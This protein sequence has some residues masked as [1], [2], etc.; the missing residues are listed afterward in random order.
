[1]K[2]TT[3]NPHTE[4][5]PSAAETLVPTDRVLAIASGAQSGALCSAL[6]TAGQPEHVTALANQSVERFRVASDAGVVTLPFQV[7]RY[8][9]TEVIG[10]GGMGVVYLAERIDAELHQHVA[11][12][13]LPSFAQAEDR[14]RFVRE[15]QILA[16]MEHPNIA[17]FMDGGLTSEGQP[18]FAMEWVQ[19]APLM[20][21]VRAE[22]NIRDSAC[23]AS[24][25]LTALSQRARLS[26]FLKICDAVQYAHQRLVVH[27]D[28][29]PGNILV[30]ASG[31]PK[32][33]DFGIA[34]ILAADQNI[35]DQTV[36]GMMTPAYAAPEQLLGQPV[37]TLTD[38]FALGVILYE[39]L[40]DSRPRA[41][42]N[43]AELVRTVEQALPTPSA[44]LKAT[45]RVGVQGAALAKRPTL[46]RVSP[47]L[48]LI[49]Q[50]A[51][52]FEPAR[53]YASAEALANDVRAA[54]GARPIHARADSWRYRFGKLLQRNPA[55]SGAFVFAL[56][57]LLSGLT[58][59]V[60]MTRRANAQAA[61]AD[62]VKEFVLGMFS[63]SD[64]DTSQLPNVSV[65]E[66]LDASAAQA[67]AATGAAW[68]QQPEVL[69]EIQT[70]M[71]G[72]YANLGEFK[73]AL[74]LLD[75]AQS[76]LT[77]RS[78][79]ESQPQRA[80]SLL[81]RAQ[82]QRGLGELAAANAAALQGVAIAPSRSNT[83]ARLQ[84]ELALVQTELGDYAA[85]Q[86]G[87]REALGEY[88]AP[89]AHERETVEALPV[90][91]LALANLLVINEQT[92]AALELLN[93]SLAVMV[94]KVGE[95]NTVVARLLLQRA[96][97]YDEQGERA[98]AALDYSTSVS[99]L[100][101]LV[102][103]AHPETL[104]ARDLQ[105]FF[106]LRDGNSAGA[107]TLLLAAI[108]E[109]TAALGVRHYMI[110]TLNTSLS[111][112][113]VRRG[114][115]ARA[116]ALALP[117]LEIREALFSKNAFSVLES[118][119]IVSTILIRLNRFE[120]AQ[121][122]VQGTIAVIETAPPSQRSRRL[123][124]AQTR[125]AQIYQLQNQPR[126]ALTLYQAIVQRE[127]RA[128]SSF[129]LQPILLHL[130]KAALAV[131]EFETARVA[132]LRSVQ[133]D[134]SPR[135]IPAHRW[136]SLL[137]QG[138]VQRAGPEPERAKALQTLKQALLE[139]QRSGATGPDVEAMRQQLVD[140]LTD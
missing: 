44:A 116:L 40:T 58:V 138:L 132:A 46:E 85:A 108:S 10:R 12:K 42:A 31:E 78:V 3:Q 117:A 95:K 14:A 69:A 133:I 60:Q 105:A 109:G 81:T 86:R 110:A 8:R 26:L 126:A 21:Y 91:Q 70:A 33:L 64:P 55:A 115:Y 67:R 111:T 23:D 45:V 88:A 119:N 54:L 59:S 7:G 139:A 52:R 120:E 127:D 98:K 80:L 5:E 18:Y 6:D 125:S 32:L 136:T 92:S 39:L 11:L 102:G 30:D 62:A 130:V 68:Q 36:T 84:A 9:A 2:P 76:T 35:S 129:D 131:G 123:S 27:R 72:A 19:G 25:P 83:R 48:D 122:M 82:A 28:L 101:A 29:K 79:R 47:D 96:A 99:T 57:A 103:A 140:S 51:M 16:G 106:T 41:G 22:C 93:Q 118:R 73:R 74:A 71:A 100:T 124:S 34:K 121:A 94:P 77:A 17:H 134:A 137:A 38:V 61:R 43:V 66:L 113:Y 1:V 90:L 87:L 13:L 128:D 24:K 4:L 107:E 114:D 50:T 56:F 15:R 63:A 112:V 53:R 89:L 75:Q 104:R 49:V 135:G 97:V 65:R 20:A 37:S